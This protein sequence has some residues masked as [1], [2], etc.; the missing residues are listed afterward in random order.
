MKQLA[1]EFDLA[2][3]P[4]LANFVPAGNEAALAHLGLWVD[5]PLRA[6]VPTYLWGDGGCG[7][8]H[9][10]RGVA[11]ELMAHGSAV[12]WLDASVLMPPAFDN[13]WDVVCLDDCHL[14]TAEQQAAAFNWFV[15]A[16]TPVEGRARWVLAAGAVPLAAGGDHSVTYPIFRA[17][18]GA[19]VP[20][21]D[22]TASTSAGPAAPV[23]RAGKAASAKKK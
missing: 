13:R 9:L 19:A 14:Y 21:G 15:N 16:Q 20:A 10:L 7:K 17:L 8:T 5:N 6:P 11:G 3:L 22:P 18:A 4:R 1:L 23:K 2:P 12:G